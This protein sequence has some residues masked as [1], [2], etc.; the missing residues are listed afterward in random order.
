MTAPS[1]IYRVVVH[2]L[3]GASDLYNVYYVYV[4]STGANSTVLARWTANVKADL[5][6]CISEAVTIV[7]VTS[8]ELASG[9]QETI[10]VAEV[11]A[12]SGEPTPP[13]CSQV[14]SFR[15]TRVGRKYRGRTYIPGISE[16]SQNGGSLTAG[17]MTNLTAL[18]SAFVSGWLSSA[19]GYMVV[20]HRADGTYDRV[21]TAIPR[22]TVYTQRRRTVGMGA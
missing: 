15:T 4:P 22:Q 17:A 7:D 11:G 10:A 12:V 20:Y 13:Q 18:G 5:K 6:A 1:N 14:I 8:T 9:A 2:Y 16:G 3:Q 21:I 19:S